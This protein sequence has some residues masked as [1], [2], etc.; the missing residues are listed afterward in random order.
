MAEEQKGWFAHPRKARRSAEALRLLYENASIQD[1]FRIINNPQGF[2]RKHGFSEKNA[3]NRI[4]FLK[5]VGALV[6]R[7]YEV[8]GGAYRVFS[9]PEEQRGFE[10]QNA[11]SGVRPETPPP[12]NN[13]PAEDYVKPIDVVNTL[14]RIEAVAESLLKKEKRLAERDEK[15]MATLGEIARALEAQ[16]AKQE[17]KTSS[18]D[19]R[20]VLIGFVS[21]FS[22]FFGAGAQFLTGITPNHKS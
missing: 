5:K 14:G 16:K 3:G 17:D 11:G 19:L 10:K 2:L 9:T 13:K 18:P 15:L 1:G 6:P 12:A 22:K 4:H 21:E 7:G 20:E 8:R